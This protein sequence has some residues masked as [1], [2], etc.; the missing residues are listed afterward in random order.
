MSP[1]LESWRRSS[2]SSSGADCVELGKIGVVRDSKNPEG[3]TIR[4]DL[5]AFVAAVKAD[6][7]IR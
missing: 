2:F 6:R 4:A 1:D 3:A 7:L 5:G